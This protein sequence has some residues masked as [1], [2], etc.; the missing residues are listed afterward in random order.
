L[1]ISRTPSRAAFV[2]YAEFLLLKRM[3]ESGIEFLIAGSTAA[4]AYGFYVEPKDLDI[5]VDYQRA[6]WEGLL[7]LTDEVDPQPGGVGSL[8]REPTT[9]PTQMHVNLGRGL[10]VLSGFRH[11]CFSELFPRQREAV[12]AVELL[13]GE[14]LTVPVVDLSDLVE[15][16]RARGSPRDAELIRAAEELSD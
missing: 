6:R 10:D 4:Y 7:L 14:Q 5:V 2:Q 9:F 11:A 8:T 16:W 15:S 12:V 1:S 3:R 13:E